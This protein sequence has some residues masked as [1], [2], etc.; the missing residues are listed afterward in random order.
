[1]ERQPEEIRW[2]EKAKHKRGTHPVMKPKKKKTLGH[3]VWLLLPRK[4]PLSPLSLSLLNDLHPSSDPSVRPLSSAQ[5]NDNQRSNFPSCYVFK[6]TS[7]SP[8]VVVMKELVR[9]W[10]SVLERQRRSSSASAYICVCA[11]MSMWSCTPHLMWMDY[12]DA[13]TERWPCLPPADSSS[14]KCVSWVLVSVVERLLSKIQSCVCE[15]ERE[16]FCFNYRHGDHV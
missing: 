1:M 9:L 3:H 8:F 13:H 14:L 15:R 7:K 11:Y 4:P 5:L 10:W 2:E 6:S 16:L 12:T